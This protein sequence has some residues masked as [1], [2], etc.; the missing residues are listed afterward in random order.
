MLKMG[1]QNFV[2]FDSG[3]IYIEE[4][5]QWKFQNFQGNLMVYL[6][7]VKR[8]SC[9]FKRCKIF[10]Q[11]IGSKNSLKKVVVLLGQI[12]SGGVFGQTS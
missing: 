3:N 9:T 11:M 4:K 5:K 12:D 6:N 2:P 7:Y 10:Q 8:A 1:D